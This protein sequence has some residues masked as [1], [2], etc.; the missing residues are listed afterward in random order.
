MKEAN[1]ALFLVGRALH[2]TAY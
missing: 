2:S 1:Y